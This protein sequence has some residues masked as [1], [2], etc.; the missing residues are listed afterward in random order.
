MEGDQHE[1]NV[2]D[3]DDSASDGDNSNIDG[4]EQNEMDYNVIEQPNE[5]DNAVEEPNGNDIDNAEDARRNQNIALIC[6]LLSKHHCTASLTDDLLKVIDTIMPGALPKTRYFLFKFMEDRFYQ[7]HYVC[8]ECYSYLGENPQESCQQCMTGIDKSDL[9]TNNMYILTVSLTYSLTQYCLNT[10]FLKLIDKCNRKG[11]Q[12][13]KMYAKHEQFLAEGPCCFTLTIATDGGIVHKSRSKMSLWPLFITVN[14][15]PPECQARY[16]ILHSLWYGGKP[17]IVSFFE[18]LINEVNKINEEGFDIKLQSGCVINIKLRV[19][20]AVMDSPARAY[21]QN[22]KQFNGHYGCGYCEHP[23]ENLDG[24]KYPVLAEPPVLR[25]HESVVENANNAIHQNVAVCGVKGFSP[26]LKFQDFDIVR[27]CPP[28]VMHCVYHGT[29]RRTVLLWFDSSNHHLQTCKADDFDKE[30]LVLKPPSSI[31]R[32]PRSLNERLD[33]KASEWKNFLLYYSVFVLPAT[34]PRNYRKH[35]FLL[36]FSLHILNTENVSTAR[37]QLAQRAFLKFLQGIDE[38]YGS[39][40]YTYNNHLLLHLCKFYQWWGPVWGYNAFKY[41]D[42]IRK[43]NFYHHGSNS[44][45]IQ[46]MKHYLL[47]HNVQQL[48]ETAFQHES[49]TDEKKELRKKLLGRLCHD[50]TV[51]FLSVI[52]LI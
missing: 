25:T 41:E 31:T 34:M 45:N 5:N 10:D 32:R 14:E 36:S 18:P 16:M 35:F 28:D 4:N 26:L 33:W 6:A 51:V 29:V 40:N 22:L 13:G 7:V 44:V 2:T 24:I 19:T 1:D 50:S 23:G 38:L 46:S 8:K 21:F 49:A 3:Q 27:G 9:Y 39:T 30:L 42:G 37:L 15:L 52:Y 43:L 48:C 47:H 17:S 12:T 20:L 11:V